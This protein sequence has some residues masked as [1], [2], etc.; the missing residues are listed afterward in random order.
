MS[1]IKNRIYFIAI[2]SAV[3][4]GLWMIALYEDLFS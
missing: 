4:P 1:G 2:I 3:P